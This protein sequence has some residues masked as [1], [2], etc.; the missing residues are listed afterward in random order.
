MNVTKV[1]DY[2]VSLIYKGLFVVHS[3]YGRALEDISKLKEMV[4]VRVDCCVD[5]LKGD[6]LF[7]WV[8]IFKHIRTFGIAFSIE[9]IF[10]KNAP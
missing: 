5:S 4:N 1:D 2:I 7:L 3:V 8:D 9:R 6:D 10:H